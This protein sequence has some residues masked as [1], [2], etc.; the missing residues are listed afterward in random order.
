MISC[1]KCITVIWNKQAQK[2]STQIRD[3]KFVGKIKANPSPVTI[4]QWKFKENVGPKV[5]W[6]KKILHAKGK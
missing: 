6:D 3:E 1:K 2:C 4:N 5:I